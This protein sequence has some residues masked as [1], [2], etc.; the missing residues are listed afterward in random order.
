MAA[1]LVPFGHEGFNKRF[2]SYPYSQKIKGA[3]NVAYNS[4]SSDPAKLS[5]DGWISS[6][7]HRKNLL[8]NFNYMGIG[9]YAGYEGK[10]YF[11]QLFALA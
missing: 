10:I 8:G 11:T 2:D 9:V 3:E 7:G 5:V 6:D 4:S 1:G